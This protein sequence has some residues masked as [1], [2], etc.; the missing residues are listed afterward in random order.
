[1]VCGVLGA[2]LLAAQMDKCVVKKNE[3]ETNESLLELV[4]PLQTSLEM[5]RRERRQAEEALTGERRL[6]G[7]LCNSLCEA[8]ERE[9]ELRLEPA[10]LREE[11]LDSESRLSSL[12]EE[13]D[14][15]DREVTPHYPWRELDAAQINP[16]PHSKLRPLVKTEVAYEGEDEEAEPTITTKQMP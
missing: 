14:P 5:E 10:R 16:Q 15:R 2:A 8:F 1:M 9:R 11:E 4:K 7:N 12:A 6:T 13:A 3:K